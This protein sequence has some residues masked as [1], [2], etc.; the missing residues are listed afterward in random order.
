MPATVGVTFC[1]RLNQTGAATAGVTGLGE[2]VR[3]TA[4]LIFFAFVLLVATDTL[5]S[6]LFFMF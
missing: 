1:T 5:G 3:V 4:V 2:C 6:C